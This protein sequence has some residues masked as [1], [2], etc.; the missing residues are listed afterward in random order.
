MSAVSLLVDVVMKEGDGER[1]SLF[2]TLAYSVK[3]CRKKGGG[4]R[5]DLVSVQAY[6][7]RD[8]RADIVANDKRWDQCGA[9]LTTSAQV[10]K[11]PT[12]QAFIDSGR[13]RMPLW[14]K[15]A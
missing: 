1:A 15:A 6:I 10:G 12:L 13:Y 5:D 14:E 9:L 3:R 11:N 7:P 2:G 4:W 8:Y